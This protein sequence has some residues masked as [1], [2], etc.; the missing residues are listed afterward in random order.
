MITPR[1]LPLLL[2]FLRGG[3]GRRWMRHAL[4]WAAKALASAI[5]VP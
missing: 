2:A 1:L 5:T 4:A 3:V